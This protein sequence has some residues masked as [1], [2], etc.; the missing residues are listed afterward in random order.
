MLGPLGAGTDG[1]WTFHSFRVDDFVA[2]T[3]QV[4]VRFVASDDLNGSIVEAAIDDF[5]IVDSGCSDCNTNGTS[6]DLDLAGAFSDFDGNGM[7]DVCQPLSE[8]VN[9]LSLSAGGTVALSLDAGPSHA[10]EIYWIFG[11]GTGTSPGTPIGSVLLPLNFDGYFKLTLFRPFAGIFTAFL[12]VLSPSGTAVA[13]FTVPP[14]IDPSL[15]GVTLN[16]AYV[17]SPMFGGA[18]FA[19]NAMPVLLVP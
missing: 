9:A 7:L 18:D 4:Q 3:S 14:G 1:G 17:S 6:D 10:G 8:D 13:A 16:H 19:S 11:S 2:P 15:A 12:G 5:E